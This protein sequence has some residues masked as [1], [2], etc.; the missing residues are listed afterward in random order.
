MNNKF[1]DKESIE[2]R[3]INAIISII[4]ADD[5]LPVIK[6]LDTTTTNYISEIHG[7]DQ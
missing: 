4:L 3:P 6:G 7:C 2:K 5:N 1:F